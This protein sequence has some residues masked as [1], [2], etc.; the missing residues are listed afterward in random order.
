MMP[1]RFREGDSGLVE[2]STAGTFVCLSA[3]DALDG[4]GEAILCG[5]GAVQD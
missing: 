5:K 1:E 4:G 3:P 2:T